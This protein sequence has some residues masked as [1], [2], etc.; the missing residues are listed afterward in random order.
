V[1]RH[2]GL[3]APAAVGTV[4]EQAR[5]HLD[6]RAAQEQRP[7]EIDPRNDDVA[8]LMRELAGIDITLCRACGARAIEPHP[9][10][11]A[12]PVERGAA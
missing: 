6:G 9:L 3:L 4:L 11:R 7:R 8:T 1:I 5:A 2:Y 10:A 12:P